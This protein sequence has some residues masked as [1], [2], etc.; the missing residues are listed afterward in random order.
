[1]A[2]PCVRA[3]FESSADPGA[4]P[5]QHVPDAPKLS[6]P[7]FEH[8][9][10]AE[11]L[12]LREFSHRIN[13]ELA[14]AISLISL[15]AH[16]CNSNEAKS[17]FAT[18]QDRLECY[19]HVQHSLQM[20]EYSTA[21]ELTTYIHQLCRA[22]SRSRLEREGIELAL[23]LYPLKMSSERCWFVGMIV[24]ELV[25]NAARHAFRNGAGSIHVEIF[26]LGTSVVCRITDN[27]RSSAEPRRGRGLSIVEALAARLQG[28]LDVQFGT[29][30]TTTTVNFPHHL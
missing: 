23:S 20:P 25:S 28:T 3:K 11:R 1:M 10:A 27:G 21:I 2:N 18:V 9:G 5:D 26:P 4:R 6:E 7:P 17:A 30:G 12:L 19:A 22:V 13:N 14:S 29:N 15:A 16:R 8:G 24:F